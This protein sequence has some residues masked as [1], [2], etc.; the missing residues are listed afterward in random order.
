MKNISTL[1]ITPSATHPCGASLNALLRQSPG[2]L[3]FPDGM[4][5]IEETLQLPS[6]THLQLSDGAVFRLADGAAKTAEDYLLRNADPHEGNDDITLEGGCFDGNQIGNPRPEG[7]FTEGYT[8]AML[9]FEN[10]RQ[11]KLL[12]L[13][14]RNAEAYYSRFTHVHDFHI[15]G[16]TFDSVKVRNNNDG[17]HLGG[18]CSHGVIRK[19]R[20]MTPGVTGDDLVALNADDA[21]TRNEVRG[22]TNGPI[23]NIEIEDLEAHSCHTF[24]RLLSVFSPI[25]NIHIRNLR[26]GCQVAAINADGARGCRVPVFDEANPPTADGVGLL[27]NIDI[28]GLKVAKVLH[29]NSHALI[30]LQERLVNF[31]V[32]H[33]ERVL[34]QDVCPEAPTLRLRHM[35]LEEGQLD[36][37]ILE[38]VDTLP[39]HDPLELF[40]V[41][42]QHLSL[43]TS[44]EPY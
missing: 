7:L 23:S 18:N 30:D 41:R 6:H 22:M 25:R 42:F 13:T 21:L 31:R 9:H 2:P 11:L 1:G 38:D 4:Y 8:G 39:P 10:V 26:G 20:A 36:D 27:E 44:A 14:M 43:R 40:P 5:L 29:Q 19:I 37:M 28:R 32:Q 35:L 34:D 15:E 17:I 3:H 24:V 33:F 16:I 12:N